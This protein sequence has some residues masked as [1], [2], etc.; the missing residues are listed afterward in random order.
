MNNRFCLSH[1]VYLVDVNGVPDDS[2]STGTSVI[3][4]QVTFYPPPKV[5]SRFQYLSV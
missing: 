4:T 1:E 5:L 2:K 3:I